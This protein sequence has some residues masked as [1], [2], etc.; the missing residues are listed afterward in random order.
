MPTFTTTPATLWVV[1]TTIT[2]ITGQV[3]APD[4]CNVIDVAGG[5]GLDVTC[6]EHE[7]QDSET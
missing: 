2:T 5:V 1:P 7:A 3:D 4:D 6:D